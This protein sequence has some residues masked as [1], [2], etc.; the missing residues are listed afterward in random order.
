MPL[1]ITFDTNEIEDFLRIDPGA[2]A[3]TVATVKSAAINEAQ[4]FLNTDFSTTVTNE[5]GTT[6]TTDN[7]APAMVKQ[8]VLSRM[9]Q[10]YEI[11]M[12]APFGV[13]GTFNTS[14]DYTL[15]K[16]YRVIQFRGFE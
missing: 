10:L 1:K 3:I 15:I 14:P 12:P 13:G 11:R 2:D 9:A 4:Q 5:D 6:T 7:E 8:W 16:P